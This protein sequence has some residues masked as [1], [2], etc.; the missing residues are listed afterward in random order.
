M[1]LFIIL[2]HSK[3]GEV[4]KTQNYMCDIVLKCIT[5]VTWCFMRAHKFE[6]QSVVEYIMTRAL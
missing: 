2:Y 3:S 5:Y 4:I 1:K 6:M